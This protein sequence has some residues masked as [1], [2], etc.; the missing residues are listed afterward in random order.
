[1]GKVGVYISISNESVKDLRGFNGIWTQDLWDTDAAL[2]WLTHC[3]FV[4][5][6]AI[7]NHCCEALAKQQQYFWLTVWG[8]GCL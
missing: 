7:Y 1:M 8:L 3:K 6:T 5:E 4:L 2:S